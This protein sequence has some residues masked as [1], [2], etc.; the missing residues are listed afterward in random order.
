M[1]GSGSVAKIVAVNVVHTIRPGY[2][3]DTAI[4]KRPVDGPVEVGVLGLDGDRQVSR[5]HG[6][7]DKAVYVYADEDAEWWAGELGRE[8]PPG[9]FGDN[10]R[11]SGLDV[12]EAPVGTRWQVGDV[13]LEVRGPRT[14]CENLSMR[15]GM[16][17]FHMRFNASGRVGALCRVLTTGVVSAGDTLLVTT[18][19]AHGV[20]V[21]DLARGPDPSQMRRLLASGVPLAGSVRAKA[22][23]IAA[24]P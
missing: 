23:R 6:G 10:I 4:D 8:I 21:G 20:T 12:T 16:D 5:S 7:K 1:N 13:L 19:P 18:V 3:K 14:P 9:L 22:R 17:K 11:T 15:M 24:R 2:F